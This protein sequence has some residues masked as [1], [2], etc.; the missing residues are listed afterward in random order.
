MLLSLLLAAAAQYAPRAVLLFSLVASAVLAGLT[1]ERL[2]LGADIRHYW[3]DVVTK[4]PLNHRAW[5]NLGVAHGKA[6]DL[7]AST[8]ATGEA[9]KLEPRYYFAIR[10]QALNLLK[11]QRYQETIDL[12]ASHYKAIGSN[13]MSAEASLLGAYALCGLGEKDR[14]IQ[15][16]Q[17]VLKVKP[18]LNDA[19][20]NVCNMLLE[21]KRYAEAVPHL[22]WIAAHSNKPSMRADAQRILQQLPASQTAVTDVAAQE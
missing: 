3:Q 13:N 7:E 1:Q 6:G 8:Q 2:S 22:R 15:V 11:L 17:T 18:D 19:Q 20:I 21:Q 10:N 16:I 5:N 9:V 14:A 4:Y 12:L